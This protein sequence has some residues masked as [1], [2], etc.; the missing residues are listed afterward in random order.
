MDF[1]SGFWLLTGGWC[2]K[3]SFD[4]I[5]T[6]LD[7]FSPALLQPSELLTPDWGGGAVAGERWNVPG[8]D[9]WETP[10]GRVPSPSNHFSPVCSLF[11]WSQPRLWPTTKLVSNHS[12][13]IPPGDRSGDWDQG[14]THPLGRA[15]L[16]IVSVR[17][18]QC[19]SVT[20]PQCQDI[21]NY[22][23]QWQ[24]DQ[25]Q[26]LAGYNHNLQDCLLMS[27]NVVIITRP[28]TWADP[29]Q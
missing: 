10:N 26:I 27:R 3:P 19:H 23:K 11:S 17:V 14:R 22:R 7:N 2:T 1:E 9:E 8:D 4:D 5:H 25:F 6:S 21:C 16:V 12:W 29:S 15:Y 13:W 24:S 20:V 28:D 18:S